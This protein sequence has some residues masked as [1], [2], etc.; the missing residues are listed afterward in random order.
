MFVSPR[1][2]DIRHPMLTTMCGLGSYAG[3]FPFDTPGLD[4]ALMSRDILYP[5]IIFANP[6]RR[7]NNNTDDELPRWMDMENK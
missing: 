6:G 7:C 3:Q 5:A 4:A 1:D 2:T